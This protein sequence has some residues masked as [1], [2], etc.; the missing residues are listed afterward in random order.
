MVFKNHFK[1]IFSTNFAKP[2]DKLRGGYNRSNIDCKG[3]VIHK[4]N[5][6]KDAQKNELKDRLTELF[7]EEDDD[8]KAE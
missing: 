6:A 5:R 3:K 8:G 4:R 2:L 1:K 7:P